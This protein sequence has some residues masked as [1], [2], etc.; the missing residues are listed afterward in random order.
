MPNPWIILAFVVAWIGSLAAVGRWQN[1]AGHTA[2]RVAWQAK[3]VAEVTAANAKIT[4]LEDAARVAEQ[5]HV[6][7][8]AAIST[9]Y[10]GK[11]QNA[12]AQAAADVAAVRARTI[13]LHDPGAI[14]ACPGG[15]GSPET[16]AGAGG[17]DGAAGRQLSD[18]AAQFLLGEANRADA[19]VEQ[20]NA[21]QAVIRADRA[22]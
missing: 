17:R 18:D 9:T 13:V 2:E 15:S 11:L 22:P 1:D 21:C 16:A 20:L 4:Q 14:S 12:K 8:V 6:T 7:A 10:E 19:I 3:E 5:A